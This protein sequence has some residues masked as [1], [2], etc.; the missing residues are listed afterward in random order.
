[1]LK[2]LA[3]RLGLS[4]ASLALVL[5][6]AELGIRGVYGSADFAED[7]QLAKRFHPHQKLRYRSPHGEFDAR[8]VYNSVGMRDLE[9]GRTPPPGVLRVLV[10]G[11]S[12]AEAKQVAVRDAFP[13]RLEALLNERRPS[14]VI[15]AGRSGFGAAEEYLVMRHFGLSRKPDVVIQAFFVN[16]VWD[17]MA[18]APEIEWGPD[19]LPVRMKGRHSELH[20]FVK[21]RVRMLRWKDRET[22]AHMAKLLRGATTEEFLTEENWGRTLRVIE[23]ARDL[24]H[25]VDALYLL[26]VIPLQEQVAHYREASARGV[27][28][29][30]NAMQERLSR[31]G[32][33]RGVAVLDLL[34]P[35]S[36]AGEA[37][38]FPKDGHWN[39]AGHRAAASA[40]AAYLNERLPAEPGALVRR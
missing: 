27:D 28:A 34:P 24:A 33:E 12:F 6:A 35:L 9:H 15:N 14:E 20:R 40:I 2:R 21:S 39:E 26:V 32:A 10:V 1:M 4:V 8:G 17:D 30:E 11:D 19:G 5:L 3:R 31:F 7:R 16:D 37:L 29:S 13:R 18:V 22:K 38:Y 23:G 36:R 25:G